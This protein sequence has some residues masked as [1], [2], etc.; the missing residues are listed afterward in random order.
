MYSQIKDT[1]HIRQTFILL[2]VSCAKGWTWACLCLLCFLLLNDWTRFNHIW[3]VSY[4][5]EWGVQR[6]IFV[7]PRLQGSKGQISITKSISKILIPNFVCVLT[8]ERYNTYQTGFIFCCMGNA[9]WVELW[10]AGGCPGGQIYFL[11]MVMWLIK[12]T[13]MTIRKECK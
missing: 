10:G 5:Y 13:R 6:Q 1:K 9:L 12:L 2:P 3:C 4:S 7:W 11:N 8:N